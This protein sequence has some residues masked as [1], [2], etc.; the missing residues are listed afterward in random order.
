MGAWAQGAWAD[1]A[2]KGTVWGEDIGVDT[3]PDQFDL[4]GPYINAELDEVINATQFT[5]TGTSP[6]ESLVVTPTNGEVSIQSGLY[7]SSPTTAVLG[8]TVD[9]RVT[10]SDSPG[11]AEVGTLDIGGVSDTFIVITPGDSSFINIILKTKNI[12]V[13]NTIS[14]TVQKTI[15]DN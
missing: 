6:G 12:T 4:G 2:W 1:G 5:I 3:T 11:Q 15:R 13:L 9:F 14:S 10:A 7:T 8:D